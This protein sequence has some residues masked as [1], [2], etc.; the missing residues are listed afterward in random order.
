MSWQDPLLNS[1]QQDYPDYPPPP[2]DY[3]PPRSTILIPNEEEDPIPSY[4]ETMRNSSSSITLSSL[5]TMN[6][7][8][9]HQQQQQQPHLRRGSSQS[10]LLMSTSSSMSIDRSISSLSTAQDDLLTTP[11]TPTNPTESHESSTE[12]SR[13]RN[14]QMNH[15][16]SLGL[17]FLNAKQHLALAACRDCVLLPP[18]YHAFRCFKRF[19]EELHKTRFLQPSPDGLIPRDSLARELIQPR[20]SEFFIVGIWCLVS[21]YLSY[22]ILDGLMV[23]WIVIYQTTA[24]I[25]RM[26]SVSLLI[27]CVEQ[28][29][30]SIFSPWDN[31]SLHTWILISCVLTGGYIFQNFVTSN[32]DLKNGK[33]SRTIDYYNITVFAV[34]PVGL[35]SFVSMIGLLRALLILRLDLDGC[36]ENG[37]G[38]VRF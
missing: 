11:T 5:T 20:S 19:F 22:Q 25:L 12:A 33:K 13:T 34:V 27:I 32:L 35:A 31:Y 24:A 21:A 6:H 3:H 1:S 15:L 10:G 18:L 36:F 30:L 16:K 37:L 23:R 26:L 38:G 29:L 8:P 28:A 14:K 4:D 9:H 7:R 2:I 17:A